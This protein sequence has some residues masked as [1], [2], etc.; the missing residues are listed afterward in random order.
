[1]GW[2]SW[3]EPSIQFSRSL[4]G[5]ETFSEPVILRNT[6]V[7]ND[8]INGDVTVFSFPAMDADLSQGPHRGRLHLLYMDD[9]FGDMD[10]WYSH[11]DDGGETWSPDVRFNED[12]EGNGLD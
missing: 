12:L 6:N 1:V 9:V 2:C 3:H 5:G 4:D 8:V 10:L 7:F 11:S